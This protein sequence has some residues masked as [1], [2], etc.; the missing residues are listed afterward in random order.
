[1]ILRAKNCKYYQDAMAYLQLIAL[2]EGWYS[3][4]PLYRN[5]RYWHN[6][7]NFMNIF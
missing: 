6:A 2:F 5:L 7:D 4:C 1:M 3:Q